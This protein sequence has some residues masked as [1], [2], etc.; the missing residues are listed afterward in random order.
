TTFTTQA[1]TVYDGVLLE[2]SELTKVKLSVSASNGIVAINSDGTFRYY[3]DKGFTGTDT[4]TFK[5]S[6][7]L[8]WSEDTLVT[9]NVQ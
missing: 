8:D 9:V 4:F 6:N 2:K 1:E 7:G 3:P 5:I